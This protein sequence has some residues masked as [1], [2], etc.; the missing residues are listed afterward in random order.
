MVIG[1]FLIVGTFA[2][3]VSDPSCGSGSLARGEVCVNTVT[4]EEQSY[5]EA[6]SE[7]EAGL[8][9]GMPIIGGLVIIAGVWTAVKRHRNPDWRGQAPTASTDGPVPPATTQH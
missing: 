4:G 7:Q 6:Q 1:V 8:R 3:G 5:D 9:V 2:F